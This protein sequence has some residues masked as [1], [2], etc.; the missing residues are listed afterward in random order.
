MK[1]NRIK[2][3]NYKTLK[4]VDLNH[5]GNL[6]VL[7]GNNSS[8][9]S[10]LIEACFLGLNYFN[11]YEETSQ[12]L[13]FNAHYHL[14]HNLETKKPIEITLQLTFNERECMDIFPIDAL[15]IIK[16]K[17]PES[18]NQI[19][20]C[21]TIDKPQAGWKTN[22]IKW[23]DIPLVIDNELV[24]PKDLCK[25]FSF[26]SNLS[27]PK[28]PFPE[29]TAAKIIGTIAPRLQKKIKGSFKL[30]TVL[31]DSNKRSTD[32]TQRELILNS[33]T[34]ATLNS[35]ME[36][37][38][39]KVIKQWIDFETTIE[40][41]TRNILDS[42][43]GEIFARRHNLCLPLQYLGGGDQEILILKYFL[44]NKDF[45]LAIEEPEM[46]LHPQTLNQIFHEIKAF[47]TISQI[48]VV[49]HSPTIIDNV[50]IQNIWKTITRKNET[51]FIG[52]SNKTEVQ[53]MLMEYD[54]PL[55]KFLFADKIVVV[56]GLLEKIML[57]IFAEKMG[58]NPSI[59]SIIHV[60]PRLK[61]T[62]SLFQRKKVAHYNLRALCTITKRVNASLYLLLNN[63]AT[64]EISTLLQENLLSKENYVLLKTEIEKYIPAEIF[65]KVM[66]KH[67]NITLHDIDQIPKQ[68]EIENIL[69]KHNKLHVGWKPFIAQ[70]I[71]ENIPKEMIP[72]E[73]VTF[74]N[75]VYR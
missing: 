59:L 53:A 10:N 23:S 46:H 32:I 3:K 4:N 22:Y 58:E 43:E 57:P 14:W 2:I 61:S 47:S 13:H 38:K 68:L 63:I 50:N 1:I 67:Y 51:T 20:F 21:R 33:D 39:Q 27:T 34:Y 19:T 69:K 42:R 5:L 26:S 62:P 52:F 48:F 40:A 31:R 17:R 12:P 73:I 55:S 28:K 41:I 35:I 70:K 16:E 49:T 15:K 56:D 11:L 65:V 18:Y 44:L 71:A 54:V 66:D 60:K 37:R 24:T 72:N 74:L 7:I 75:N 36:S 25:A 9:K 64:D 30:L 29:S 6:V 45:I 8:G